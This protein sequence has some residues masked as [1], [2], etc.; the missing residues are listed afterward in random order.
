MKITVT[1]SIP[2]HVAADDAAFERFTESIL[3][4]AARKMLALKEEAMQFT[5]SAATRPLKDEN[6]NMTGTI[7]LRQFDRILLTPTV[8]LEDDSFKDATGDEYHAL[9]VGKDG[10]TWKGWAMMGLD[11]DDVPFLVNHH[12]TP[13]DVWKALHSLYGKDVSA[14]QLASMMDRRA[15][16]VHLD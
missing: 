4:Q 14:G 13:A 8:R 11:D 6:G 1:L 9:R 7:V 16:I 5:D 10:V 3:D 2:G 15:V 12:N